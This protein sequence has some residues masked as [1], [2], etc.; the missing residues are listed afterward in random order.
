MIATSRRHLSG[1]VHENRGHPDRHAH[2]DLVRFIK[3]GIRP[4]DDGQRR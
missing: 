2:T 3:S 4:Q 1:M